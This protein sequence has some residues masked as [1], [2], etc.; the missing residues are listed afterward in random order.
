MAAIA[1]LINNDRNAASLGSA[2]AELFELPAQRLH[3]WPVDVVISALLH[4][5]S[6]LRAETSH[7]TIC[8]TAAVR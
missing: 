3:N 6:I 2:V 1:W 5:A 8:R 4:R 7:R